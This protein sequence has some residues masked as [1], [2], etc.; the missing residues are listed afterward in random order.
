MVGMSLL[1]STDMPSDLTSFELTSVLADPVSI[2]IS[3]SLP[4]TLPWH[5][6]LVFLDPG[7]M[8]GL[9]TSDSPLPSDG[10]ASSLNSVWVFRALVPSWEPYGCI[11]VQYVLAVCNCYKLAFRH[12]S[13]SSGLALSG[14]DDL[15][16]R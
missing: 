1:T 5:L 2:I 8:E 6:M 15:S 14:A 4:H 7:L 3:T 12:S 13:S 9:S 10:V 11:V 16:E